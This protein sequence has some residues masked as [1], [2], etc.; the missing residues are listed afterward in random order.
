VAIGH[1]QAVGEED[2]AGEKDE[3]DTSNRVNE[4]RSRR[5]EARDEGTVDEEAQENRERGRMMEGARSATNVDEN[6]QYTTT[7]EGNLPPEPPLPSPPPSP[8]PPIPNHPERRDHNDDAMKS[9]RTAARRRAD[10][11]HGPGGETKSRG[12]APPSV[13]LEGEKNKASS[14]NVEVD[15]VKTVDTKVEDNHDTQQTPRGPVG[16][17]DGDERR[18]DEPTDPP[19]E[20]EGARRGKGESRVESRTEPIESTVEDVETKE[21]RR[22]G[23]PRGRG[24]NEDES[25]EVEGQ[26]KGERGGQSEVDACHRDGRTNDTGDVTSGTTHDSK[27]VEAGPLANDEAGQQR[28]GK[29]STSTNSPTPSTPSTIATKRP[30]RHVNLPRRRGRLK[31]TT[32]NISRTRVYGIHT[33]SQHREEDEGTEAR[34]VD[35]VDTT[36]APASR[37]LP[38]RVITPA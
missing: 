20:E 23:Q 26:V 17:P 15:D 25:R 32:T 13:R 34:S 4:R 5:E 3:P 35:T 7:D 29:P 9:S 11:V 22:G 8:P 27:R 2:E 38:Y 18:P 37:Q 12:S 28:N 6:G 31:S 21:S 1:R 14:L 30:T 19:D 10:A 16:T 24:G 36:H 33:K